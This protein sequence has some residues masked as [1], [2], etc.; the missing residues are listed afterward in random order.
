[1]VR[2]WRSCE[3]HQAKRSWTGSLPAGAGA[4]A[5]AAGA[6]APLDLSAGG[7]VGAPQ[8]ERTRSAVV[9]TLNQA[10]LTVRRILASSSPCGAQN[11]GKYRAWAWSSSSSIGGAE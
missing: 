2:L 4:A 1:M 5:G 7:E 9:R 8:A 10:G 6:A 3:P 11:W